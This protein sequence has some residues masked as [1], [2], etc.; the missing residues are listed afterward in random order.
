M[1]QLSTMVLRCLLRGQVSTIKGCRDRDLTGSMQ[2]SLG[3]CTAM[4]NRYMT[5]MTLSG[6]RAEQERTSW[7]MDHF[8]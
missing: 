8:T 1:G 4:S 6:V 7:W 2:Y 3:H 5:N